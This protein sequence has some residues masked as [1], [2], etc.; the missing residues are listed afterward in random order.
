MNPESSSGIYV[1][2]LMEAKCRLITRN[3]KL[4]EDEDIKKIKVNYLKRAARMNQCAKLFAKL[5]ANF[6]NYMMAYE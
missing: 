4:K 2:T 6:K 5:V 3:R 1:T